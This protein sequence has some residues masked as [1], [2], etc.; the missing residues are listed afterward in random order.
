MIT[1]EETSGNYKDIV[2]E[3]CSERTVKV[4]DNIL[5]K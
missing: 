1:E 2:S 3:R 4:A 5:D